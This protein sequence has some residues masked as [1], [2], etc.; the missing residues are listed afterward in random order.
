VFALSEVN[1][2]AH[3]LGYYTLA[4][5]GFGWYFKAEKAAACGEFGRGVSMEGAASRSDGEA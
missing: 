3:I 2:P 5:A 1:D 4:L